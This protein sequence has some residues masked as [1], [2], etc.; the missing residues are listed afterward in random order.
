M[1]KEECDKAEREGRGSWSR[2]QD[3]HGRPILPLEFAQQQ[4]HVE[5]MAKLNEILDFLKSQSIDDTLEY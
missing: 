3:Q 2:L 1:T 4:A 5:V